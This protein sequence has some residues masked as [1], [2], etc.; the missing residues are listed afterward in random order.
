MK[1][2]VINADSGVTATSPTQPTAVSAI[3]DAISLLTTMFIS[4]V[5]YGHTTCFV[6]TCNDNQ[7][8]FRVV[9]GEVEGYLCS[10]IK[11]QSISDG[12]KSVVGMSCPV[13]LST[14]AHKE[15]A[16]VVIEYVDSLSY[17]VSK[18]C[19]CGS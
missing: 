14:F 3:A 4:G 19:C 12:C 1:K 8:L 5:D 7:C 17:V 2:L 9:K 6:V 11:I 10:V 15:E 13:N 16:V 18:A